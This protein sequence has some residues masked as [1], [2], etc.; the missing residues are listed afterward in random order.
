MNTMPGHPAPK[1]G[2]TKTILGLLLAALALRLALVWAGGQF[3]WPDES[4]YVAARDALAAIAG[5]QVREGLTSLVA[6]GDHVG[7]KLLGLMPAMLERLLEVNDPRLAA[8]FFALFSWFGLVFL[9]GWMRQLGA[10]PEAQAWTVLLVVTC[11][12]LTFYVRHLFPYDPSMALAFAALWVGAK[13]RASLVRVAVAGILAGCAVLVYFGHWLL[14]GVVLLLLCLDREM[15]WR[16]ILARGFA[17]GFGFAGVLLAVWLL[18]RWGAGTMVANARNFS[19]TITQGDF[20]RGW[21]LVWEYFW[22]TEGLVTLGW[23]AV[24]GYAGRR[25]WR[26]WRGRR[27]LPPVWSRVVLALVL[28]YGGLMLLSDVVPKFVIYGRSARQL[29]PFF[30]VAGGLVLAELMAVSSRR[31]LF[32]WGLGVALVVNAAWHL[33]P[34]LGQMFPKEFRQV[35]A[36]RLT[37]APPAEAGRSYYRLVNVDHYLFEAERLAHPPEEILLARR[38]PYEFQP[39]LYEGSSAKQRAQRRATDQRM[40]LVRVRVPDAWMIRG[41]AAGMITMKVRFAPGRQGM[42]E[43]LLSLGP[44]SKGNLFFVRYI[45]H[46]ELVMGMESVGEVQ[47]VGAPQVYEA[48]REYE[49]TF[50]S[51][52]LMPPPTSSA[53][54]TEEARLLYYANLV[55]VRLDG[56]EV[57]NGLAAPFAVRPDEAYAGYNFVRSDS[58][59]TAFSGE[60]LGVRRGGYPPLPAGGLGNSDFGAVRMVVWLPAAAAGTPEPLLV[61]GVPNHAAL[62]YVRVLPGGK[63]K[64]G[65][66]FWGVG[67]YESEELAAPSDM[68]TEIV[69]H[70]PALYPP[71]GDP[72]WG[73]VPRDVQVARRSRMALLLNGRVVLER[74][75]RETP[76]PPAPVAFGKNPVGGSWVGEKFTGRLIQGMRLPLVEPAA[77]SR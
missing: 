44:K 47:L 12:S 42:A 24:A 34:V 54:P 51:G 35:A 36:A 11:T 73:A 58:A 37:T 18:D 39:Y 4:R 61:V 57:L 38:H 17:A 9:W 13:D 46:R 23:L 65:A 30:C 40:Q 77:S 6:Q 33:G 20:G 28:I 41:E 52:S 69:L 45:S 19:G 15:A 63:V 32:A 60:I 71:V 29:S 26:D 68:P 76:V 3:F 7:F 31:K 2:R 75:V 62:G 21:R 27:E 56:Q 66:E 64:L 14:T 16:R 53:D 67:A 70:L 59:N 48:G 55:S 5:G 49:L 10:S 50:F 72:R 43:P 1:S 74:E 25:V 8:G 22:H